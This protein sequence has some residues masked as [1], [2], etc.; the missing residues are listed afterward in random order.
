MESSEPLSQLA[1]GGKS[2][3]DR[4]SW[5]DG[6]MASG[7]AICVFFFEK[8]DEPASDGADEGLIRSIENAWEVRAIL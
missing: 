5:N 8:I 4:Q 7:K 1:M 3:V 6:I 2:P